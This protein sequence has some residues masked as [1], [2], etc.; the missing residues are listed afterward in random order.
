MIAPSFMRSRCWQINNID[1][2]SYRYQD[3]AKRGSLNTRH[4]TIAVH[5]SLKCTRWIDFAHNHIRAHAMSA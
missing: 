4:H 2:A 1:I 5:D 3:I